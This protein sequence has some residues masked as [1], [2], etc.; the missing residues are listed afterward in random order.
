[1]KLWHVF[2][3]EVFKNIHDRVSLFMMLILMCLNIIGGL[4][5]SNQNWFRRTPNT[6]ESIMIFVF[7]I[8]VIASI[9]FL[10]IY[11]Y[12]MARTDYKNK[13]MSLII[14][15]GVSRVQYYVVKM[16]SILLFSFLS[17]LMLVMLPLLIVVLAN[18]GIDISSQF[19]DFNFNV[20]EFLPAMGL[21][22][23]NWL[24]M[25]S[26]LM[27]SVIITKG[28]GVTLFV[29]FGISIASSLFFSI[30][31]ALLGIDLW[32]TNNWF[33]LFQHLTTIGILA[34]VGILILRKQD[35]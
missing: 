32:Q 20:N 8:S 25:F 3:M 30:V 24:S 33:T 7:I 28:R 18:G 35:L 11:P 26:M 22:I 1:M 19:F 4:V 5:L 21:M 31:Q 23:L 12:Q 29:Y 16:G 14:A 6:F 10:F 13:V 17:I 27:A 34:L 15:S 9:I 2:R